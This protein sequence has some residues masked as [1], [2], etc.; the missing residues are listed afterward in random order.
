MGNQLK[1]N[2]DERDA[3]SFRSLF[4]TFY[5]KVK[6]MLM[7][8][9]AAREAAEEIS[10]E[11]MFAVWRKS[12]QFSIDK[13]DVSGWIYTIARNL[14]IDRLRRQAVWQRLC[15]D[16]ETMER[17]RNSIKDTQSAMS[18]RDDLES[19]LGKLPPEQ[20]QVVRLSFVDGHTQAEIAA[21]LALPLGTVKSRM[22]LAFEKLRS[23]AEYEI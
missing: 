3:G 23:A 20:L 6:T 16:L 18:E 17:L 14:H 22:C 10:Q 15:M 4:V 7:R 13:G 19:A 9:G 8:R 1:N 11:T 5:P 12:H 21:K 2:P